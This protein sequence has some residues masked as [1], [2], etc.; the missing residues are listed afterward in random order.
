MI[1]GYEKSLFNFTLAYS[2]SAHLTLA[3]SEMKFVPVEAATVNVLRE[4]GMATYKEHFSDIWTSTGIDLYLQQN[5][6][7]TRLNDEI[8]NG[9]VQYFLLEE[10][11]RYIGFIKICMNRPMTPGSLTRGIELEKIYLLKAFSGKG[12]GSKAFM[13]LCDYARNKGEK[14]VW[15]NVLKSNQ[16]AIK[17]YEQFGFRKIDQIEF[18]TDKIKIDMW[19]MKFDL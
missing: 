1:E 9:L 7:V 8:R 16:R 18:S 2:V 11:N 15:L 19:V 5:F 14:L 10:E 3:L 13:F 6:D 12:I 4:V 17:F